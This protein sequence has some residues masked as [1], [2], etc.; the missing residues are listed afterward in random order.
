MCAKKKRQWRLR[1]RERLW[2]EQ[3]Q[4]CCWCGRM[5][6]HWSTFQSIDGQH[7]PPALATIEHLR[8]KFDKKRKKEEPGQQRWALACYECNNGRAALRN[9]KFSELKQKNRSGVNG[10]A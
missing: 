1:R 3:K 5:M 6:L 7:F 8:D 4:R 9:R 2:G 10:A